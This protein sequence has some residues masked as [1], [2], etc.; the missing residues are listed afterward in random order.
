MKPTRPNII[1]YAQ[2]EYAGMRLKDLAHAMDVRP[3][4]LYAKMG[5]NPISLWRMDQYELA[6]AIL[7]KARAEFERRMIGVSTT[8][9]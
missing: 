6:M 1:T 8:G 4:T 3:G 5:P 9:V 7:K 2:I